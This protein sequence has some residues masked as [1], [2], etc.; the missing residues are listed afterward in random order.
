[1][2]GTQ[3]ADSLVAPV[4]LPNLPAAQAVQS[5][6]AGKV[7]TQRL[8]ES[9]IQTQD[10]VVTSDGLQGASISISR[11]GSVMVVGAIGDHLGSGSESIVNG[12]FLCMQLL[13]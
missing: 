1:V 11:D 3:A 5:V 9:L 7:Y 4:T 8:D 13:Q 2:Q 6:G 12:F 10:P